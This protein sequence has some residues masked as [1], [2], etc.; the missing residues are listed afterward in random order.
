MKKHSKKSLAKKGTPAV[1]AEPP[2]RNF[3]QFNFFFRKG[4]SALKE[5]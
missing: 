4:V 5:V 2:K 1:S 3:N